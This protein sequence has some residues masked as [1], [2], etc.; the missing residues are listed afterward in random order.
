MSVNNTNCQF[1]INKLIIV[2]C[3]AFTILCF[4]GC[5]LFN[6]MPET[7]LEKKRTASDRVI[8]RLPGGMMFMSNF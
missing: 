2:I 1:D 3:L 5:S 8:R 7:D 6:N 4:S